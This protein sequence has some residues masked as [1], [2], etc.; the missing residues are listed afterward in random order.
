MRE[1]EKN[2]K[3]W[4]KERRERETE[5]GRGTYRQIESERIKRETE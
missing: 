2:G 1:K 5:G 4:M 3:E